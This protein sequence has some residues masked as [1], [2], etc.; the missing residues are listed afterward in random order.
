MPVKDAQD[1]LPDCI[2]SIQQ[3]GYV[4]WELVAVNDHSSDK[5]GSILREF[6]N[7]DERITVF[8]NSGN[9]IIPALRLAYSKASGQFI[10]RMDADDLML[11]DK[12]ER[13]LSACKAGGE[14]AIAT[15]KVSYFSDDEL[16]DGF[17]KYQNWLNDLIESG[18]PFSQIFK[19]CPIA[20]PNWMLRRDFLNSI[21]AFEPNVYPEDYDLIFRSWVANAEPVLVN[22]VTHLWR[23]HQSRASRTDENYS[24]NTF[25]D[26]KVTYF[27]KL[28]SEGEQIALYGAGKKGKKLAKLFLKENTSLRWFSNNP[29]KIGKDIYEVKLEND[30]RI[31]DADS[32]EKVVVAISSPEEQR[33]IYHRFNEAGK[34]EGRDYYFFC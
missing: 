34:Q 13:L 10:T 21:G 32:P 5:S 12:L 16:K 6:S 4:N 28:I 7:S 8:E 18:N 11:P 31:F 26:L 1:F 3:Q 2:S 30:K 15:G 22:E 9:G 27:L 17:L 14:K 24:D 25:F 29:K 19:E 33:E 23:D 20:S